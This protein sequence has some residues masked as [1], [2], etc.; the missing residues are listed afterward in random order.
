MPAK[1]G[2]IKRVSVQKDPDSEKRNLNMYVISEDS[3]GKLIKTN[4]T[5]KKKFKNLDQ[6]I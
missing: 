2:S 5:I 3:F 4:S 6:S 1:F